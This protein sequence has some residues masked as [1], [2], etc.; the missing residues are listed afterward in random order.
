MTENSPVAGIRGRS[1]PTALATAAVLIGA[2]TA[3]CNSSSPAEGAA[4]AEC[5]R[6]L[7]FFGALTGPAATLG[8]NIKN[9]AQLAVDQ[10]N[11]KHTDCT[12]QLKP[13]DSEGSPDK[14][15]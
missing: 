14:A 10:Y 2:L 9:G 4:D 3:A 6:A 11:A 5:G 7:A 12:V 1:R 15:P 13:F 8:V